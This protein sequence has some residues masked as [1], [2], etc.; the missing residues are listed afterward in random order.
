MGVGFYVCVV[1]VVTLQRDKQHKVHPLNP[2]YFP[3]YN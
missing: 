3:L 1:K 2:S